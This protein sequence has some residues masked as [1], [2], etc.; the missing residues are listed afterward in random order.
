MLQSKLSIL[1]LSAERRGVM[2]EKRKDN[3]GRVLRSGEIQRKNGLYEYKYN[4]AKGIRRSIYSWKLVETDNCPR[5]KK[6]TEALRNLE[7]QIQRDIDDGLDTYESLKISVN[8]CFDDYIRS[9]V[10]LRQ[11]TRVNYT[12]MYQKFVSKTIGCM[13]IT[14]VKYSTIKGFYLSLIHDKGFKLSTVEIINNILHPIFMTAVRD[15]IIRKNPSDGVMQEIKRGHNWESTKRHA[16]TVSEQTAFIDYMAASKKYS[17]W[18]PLITII[19][20]TG[21]RIGEIIGLRWCD[22]DFDDN[23]ISIN[24]N[25]IYRMQENGKCEFHIT[26]PKTKNSIRIIPMLDDVKAALLKTKQECL[27]NGFNEEIIDGYT[28]FIFKNRYNTVYSPHAINRLIERVRMDYNREESETAKQE[29]REP[30]FVPHFSVHNLRHTFCTRFCENET[31]IKVIQEIMGH[32]D[33]STTMDVYNEATKEKKIESF[34]N[35]EG[36]IKIC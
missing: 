3:K 25:L 12:Y 7:K 17:H 4:D 30:I 36:K 31:N 21:A 27:L 1:V 23:M 16:L 35:L 9:R 32:S 15:D 8:D 10:D 13:N 28:G 18:L 34:I 33:I 20:G 29:K 26:S 11:S 22:C 24:H 5:G 6:K 14:T 19:L 2:A